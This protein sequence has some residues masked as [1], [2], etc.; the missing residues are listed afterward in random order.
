MQT[1]A[2]VRKA[3]LINIAVICGLGI[4]RWRGAAWLAIAI[5]ALTFF[6]MANALMYWKRTQT[7]QGQR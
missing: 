2:A 6:P 4:E 3:W 7:A 5:T 1:T